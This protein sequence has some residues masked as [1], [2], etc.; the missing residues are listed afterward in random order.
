MIPDITILGLYEG[1]DPKEIRTESTNTA[2]ILHSD[3]AGDHTDVQKPLNFPDYFDDIVSE[4]WSPRYRNGIS[5]NLTG[6]SEDGR[7]V[8]VNRT[9]YRS[10]LLMKRGADRPYLDHDVEEIRVDL[11]GFNDLIAPLNVGILVL[12]KDE[13]GDFLLLHRR[14]RE[15]GTDQGK[16]AVF[17]VGYVRLGEEISDAFGRQSLDELGLELYDDNLH[18]GVELKVI[19]TA[20]AKY[21]TPDMTAVA[22]TN[23]G[24][25]EFELMLT[26][27]KD[28]FET[29]NLIRCGI[30]PKSPESL[31][32][33]VY[34]NWD[35]FNLDAIS[36]ILLL[37]NDLYGR[38]AYRRFST[39][40]MS[41]YGITIKERNPFSF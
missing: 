11:E 17:P 23:L 6:L 2:N 16:L 18:S 33:F 9:D 14:G 41:R 15:T 29:E 22:R 4:L 32:R 34:E 31:Y 12:G 1:L 7:V 25:G 20:R 36:K 39:D 8:R 28:K 10:S 30:D 21:D 37:A 40:L 27:A 5:P 13:Y 24:Y 35:S 26:T 38:E 19:G 3:T